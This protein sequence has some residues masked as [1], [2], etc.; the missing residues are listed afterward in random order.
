MRETKPEKRVII[1]E[2]L[3]LA[4]FLLFPLRH[5]T[6][7]LDLYDTGYNYGNY[8]YVGAEYMGSMWLFSTYLTNIVGHLFTLLPGGKTLLGLGIY[9]GLSITLLASM[10]YWFCTRKL[11]MNRLLT[12]VGELAAMCMCWCPT[13]KLYDYFTYLLFLGCFLLLYRGLTE[14]KPRSLVLAGICLGTNVFVRFSNLPE[15]GMILAVWAYH[16]LR[17][18]QTGKKS[19]GLQDTLW[20]MAGYF[21]AVLVIGGWICI[22]YGLSAYVEGISLLF[23]MTE[24]ATDYQASSMVMG[25]IRPYWESLY[26]ILRILVFVAGAL[27]TTVL[28]GVIAGRLS[29]RGEDSERGKRIFLWAGR[30]GAALILGVM[31]L[32]LFQKGFT[33]FKYYS[34]D[35]I[36]WPGTI[37]LFLA[38]GMSAIEIVRPGSTLE[39][40]LLGGMLILTLMITSLGSNNGI[41]PSMNNLFIAGP[42]VLREGARFTAW[43][44]KMTGKVTVGRAKFYLDLTS[45]AMSLWV[46]IGICLCQFAGFGICF[47]FC[48]G[49]GVQETGYRVKS[50]PSLRGITMSRERAEQMEEL[51]LFVQNN[52]LSGKEVLLHGWVPSLS[53]YL[54]MPPALHSW[55]DLASYGVS[56]MEQD[57]DRIRGEI[58]DQG[59]EK[60][61]VITSKLYGALGPDTEGKM[62]ES[63]EA[64]SKVRE[65]VKWKLI[66]S[67][68]E[69]FGYVRTFENERFVVWEA[70]EER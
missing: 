20:C 62:Y 34:Y 55:N 66:L 3:F 2:C 51:G 9:T 37:F 48:E 59:G 4:V 5:V 29:G 60:P 56:V 7:G 30:I 18:I 54:E 28:A 58:L 68:M 67:F 35:P 41:L 6:W 70:G 13:A 43:V 21:G 45:L 47:A 14:E 31:V 23:A 26:W 24:T 65:D 64:D 46:M 44:R 52:K 33:T 40:R 50:I 39:D 27:L 69:D 12:F 16:L 42:Y 19:R 49:T 25:M 22:R 15:A 10:G 8:R 11:G 57:M 17:R 1:A 53:F 61:V 32:W 36:T 38:M 63:P